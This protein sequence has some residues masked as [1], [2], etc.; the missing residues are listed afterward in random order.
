MSITRRLALAGAASLGLLF[1]SPAFAGATIAVSLWDQGGDMSTTSNLGYNMGGDMSQAT[2]GIDVSPNTVS[3]GH[4][5][6]LVTN[7]S[8]DTIHEMVVAPLAS[9][10]EVLPYVVDQNRV[11]E[12]GAKS[13]GEVSE[14]EPHAAGELGINLKPGTYILYCNIPGHYASG[15]WAILNVTQ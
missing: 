2:M 7:A 4:V 5:T 10:D 11:D 13:L 8:S 15:M 3:A 1:A 14:L 6:F 9:Q 12:D